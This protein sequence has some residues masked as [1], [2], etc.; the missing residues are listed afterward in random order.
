MKKKAENEKELE[1]PKEL[2]ESIAGLNELMSQQWAACSRKR[3]T[4][5]SYNTCRMLFRTN[6]PHIKK[7]TTKNVALPKRMRSKKYVFQCVL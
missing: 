4:E 1:L 6:M 2:L 5:I 7:C 3:I